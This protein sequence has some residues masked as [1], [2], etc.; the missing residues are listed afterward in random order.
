MPIKEIKDFLFENYYKWVVFSNENEIIHWNVLKKDLLVLANKL[1]EKIPDPRNI[2]EHYQLFIRKKNTNSVKQSEIITYQPK[3]FENPKIVDIK[4]VIIK[5]PQNLHKLSK[6]I[7]R[8]K[9]IG[10]NNSLYSD[11]KKVEFF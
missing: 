9:K 5:H 2:K 8:L 1:I 4:A 6:T 11:T 3:T 10:S 7:R